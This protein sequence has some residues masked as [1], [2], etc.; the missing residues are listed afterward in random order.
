MGRNLVASF[1]L[2]LQD[3][4]SAG[5]GALQR[6]LQGLASMVRR[7]ALIGGAAGALSFA[8]P[9]QSAAAFETRLRDVAITAGTAAGELPQAIAQMRGELEGLASQYRL[10]TTGL[11]G[12]AEVLTARG[13]GADEVREYTRNIAQLAGASGAAEV[14]LAN[15]SVALNRMLGLTSGADQMRALAQT[16]RAGQLGGAEIRDM[17]QHLPGV[18]SG[19]QA[20]GVTGHRA[21]QNAAALFQ[22]TRDGFGSVSEAAGGIRQLIGQLFSEGTQ[23]N[24][25]D[26][27]GIDL[28]AVFADAQRQ[29]RRGVDIDPMEAIFQRLRQ[30]LVGRENL[31]FQ[32]IPDENAR[33]AFL[34]WNA[35]AGRYL[36]IRRELRATGAG[37]VDDGVAMRTAGLGADWRLLMETM[38]QLSNRLGDAVGANLLPVLQQFLGWVREMDIAFPGAID[39][40]LGYGGAALGI[41]AALGAIGLV[42]GPIGAGLTALASPVGL[43]VGALVGGAIHITRHWERFR[44]FFQQMGGGLTD[45]ARGFVENITGLLTGDFARGAEGTMQIW[46]GVQTFFSGLW[47]T[48][49]TL[50]TDFS[51][52]VDGWTGGAVTQAVE[53]IRGAFSGLTGWFSGLWD[54]IRAPFDTFI[55]GVL[56]TVERVRAAFASIMPAQPAMAGAPPALGR[57]QDRQR[58]AAANRVGGF[59]F[60]EPLARAT[61][62]AE[63]GRLDGRVTVE[64]RPAPGAEVVGAESDNR[65]VL[66]TTPQNRGGT[67]GRP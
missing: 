40:A 11:L 3:R 17:A 62:G 28:P 9:I 29:M 19:M 4:T 33:N 8:G 57:I 34:A 54:G 23:K 45:I 50:F 24:A 46:R 20:L 52:W 55:S 58:E 15:L 14:D 1:V 30:G 43:V 2:R 22:V 21:I 60:A 51:G 18:L 32:L 66:V 67:R 47:G 25:R 59:Y 41:A 63:T 38:T 37:V 5:I 12:A 35:Q 42:L 26:L 31:V 61:A 36:D 48:V 56:A 39:S 13:F 10:T 16:L 65:Q 7:I 64:V 49:G 6:R 53:R 27:L 44:G